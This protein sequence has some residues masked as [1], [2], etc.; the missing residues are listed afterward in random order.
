[1]WAAPARRA[2][3][4]VSLDPCHLAVELLRHP[5]GMLEDAGVQHDE[6]RVGLPE[7]VEVGAEVLPVPR[8]ARVVRHLVV[9]ADVVVARHV[10][11]RHVGGEAGRDALHLRHLPGI[12]RG[13]DHVA[14][15]DREPW[16]RRGRR[17][18]GRFESTRL[19]VE[20]G[21]LRHRPHVHA[22]TPI[23]RDLLRGA[24]GEVGELAE[25][26]VGHL[27]ERERRVHVIGAPARRLSRSAAGPGRHAS[28]GSSRMKRPVRRSCSVSS[29]SARV[30]ITNGP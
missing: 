14:A 4:S 13:I 11:E 30:F 26:R 10:P 29:I 20:V 25:L 9:G 7:G 6:V 16:P 12:P 1:M 8:Q 27:H 23:A 2:W 18:D 19:L 28:P 24:A 22:V 5:F 15:D 3:R 21:H 17:R